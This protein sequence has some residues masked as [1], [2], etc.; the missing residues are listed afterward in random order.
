MPVHSSCLTVV[1]LHN[2]GF[3][4]PVRL[5]IEKAPSSV[6]SP[7][8]VEQKNYNIVVAYNVTY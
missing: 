7:D 3:F 2:V 5:F 4:I 6:I 8:L 1:A